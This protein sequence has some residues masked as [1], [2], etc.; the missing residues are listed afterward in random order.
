[1]ENKIRIAITGSNK[2][3]G[4]GFVSMLNNMGYAA[5]EETVSNLQSLVLTTTGLPQLILITTTKNDRHETGTILLL[6]KTYPAVPVMVIIMDEDIKDVIRGIKAGVHGYVLAS[7]E[8]GK[9]DKAIK[10]VITNGD[11]FFDL[12]TETLTYS[13]KNDISNP[14]K[15]IRAQAMSGSLK[16]VLRLLCTALSYEEI[17]IK[18]QLAPRTCK[19]YKENLS[20][21]LEIKSRVGLVLFA[22]KN[23]L[24]D[25]EI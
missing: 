25:T 21:T 14:V 12:T 20:D 10:T 3:L 4:K 1:M 17:A 22:V 13:E 11:Y 23:N 16:E 18:M 19:A 7:I 24:F 9:L 8:P 15:K 2:I 5:S 6:K